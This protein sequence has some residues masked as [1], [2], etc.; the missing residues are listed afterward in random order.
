MNL[1]TK[2]AAYVVALGVAFLFYGRSTWDFVMLFLLSIV[3]VAL[4]LD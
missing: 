2:L 1:V 4:G 3:F